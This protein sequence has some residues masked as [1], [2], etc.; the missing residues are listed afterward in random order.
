MKFIDIICKINTLLGYVLNILNILKKKKQNPEMVNKVYNDTLCNNKDTRICDCI[1]KDKQ[2]LIDKLKNPCIIIFLLF[3]II[4][5]CVNL[6]KEP[7]KDDIIESLDIH[8]L[9]TQDITYRI[10]KNESIK[11]YDQKNIKTYKFDTDWFI[12]HKDLLLKHNENQDFII[13]KLSHPDK[14]S[15][16]IFIIGI[17]L[18]NTIILIWTKLKK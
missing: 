13:D 15:L 10:C 1:R 11:V 16:Y 7:S 17:L 5:G 14:T 9:Q 18:F 2:K 3:S 8:Q 4:S 6:P 12:V